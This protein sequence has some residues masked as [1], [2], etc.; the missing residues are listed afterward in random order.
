MRKNLGISPEE[1]EADQSS[2]RRLSP[3]DSRYIF[4]IR[5][6][7]SKGDEQICSPPLSAES[8]RGRGGGVSEQTAGSSASLRTPR[9]HAAVISAKKNKKKQFRI[10]KNVFFLFCPFFFFFSHPNPAKKKGSATFTVRSVQSKTAKHEQYVA[11]VAKR[12][13]IKKKR[14]ETQTQFI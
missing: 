13:L 7:R 5:V 4:S 8:F 10:N 2:V 12:S 9:G 6:P 3:A 11:N 1:T 14:K